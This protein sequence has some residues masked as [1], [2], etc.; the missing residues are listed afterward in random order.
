MPCLLI[1]IVAHCRHLNS[2]L[3]LSHIAL[4]SIKEMENKEE[5]TW[6]VCVAS[7]AAD[8]VSKNP[9]EFSLSLSPR[10]EEKNIN[11]V[12]FF[13]FFIFFSWLKTKFPFS[14]LIFLSPG[15]NRTHFAPGG[16]REVGWQ[17]VK[18]HYHHHR[19]RKWTIPSLGSK[20]WRPTTF[21]YPLKTMWHRFQGLSCVL[22]I[23][24]LNCSIAEMKC[25]TATSKS[26][27]SITGRP[28][29]HLLVPVM[30]VCVCPRPFFPDCCCRLNK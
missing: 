28:N 20:R 8:S 6:C 30:F 4:T 21:I 29:N 13:H 12:F 22:H 23:P 24:A 17:T 26:Q 16:A 27:Q 18:Q 1:L 19:K 11:N 25:A 7:R 5:R 15:S 9:V 14:P 2:F 10:K 3:A